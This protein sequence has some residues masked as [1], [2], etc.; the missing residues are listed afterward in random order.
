MLFL[1]SDGMLETAPRYF[2]KLALNEKVR[3]HVTLF[4]EICDLGATRREAWAGKP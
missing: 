4:W 1:H 3:A 2:I